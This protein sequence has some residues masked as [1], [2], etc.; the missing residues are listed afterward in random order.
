MRFARDD[1]RD[2]TSFVAK[3]TTNL[4]TRCTEPRSAGKVQK[5]TFAR[6]L[7]SIDFRLLQHNLPIAEI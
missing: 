7:E 6:F 5:S 2:P 1:V 4:R 3:T